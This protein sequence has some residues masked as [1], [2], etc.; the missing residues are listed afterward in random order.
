MVEEPGEHA[1]GVE[2]VEARCGSAA[3][4]RRR[5]RSARRGASRC[6]VSAAMYSCVP[7]SDPPCCGRTSWR[8][9]ARPARR[10]RRS[11][12]PRRRT[13]RRC[14]ASSPTA[15]RPTRR[16]RRDSTR[17]GSG[18]R[19][20]TAE[21]VGEPPGR[22]DRH[23]DDPPAAPCRFDAER[24]GHGR[25]ADAARSRSRRR[26]THRRRPLQRRRSCADWSST[27]PSSDAGAP[28][29]HVAGAA[30]PAWSIE[31]AG[32][33]GHVQLLQRQRRWPRWS[34]GSRCT[35][36]RSPRNSAADAATSAAVGR[37]RVRRS[38]RRADRRRSSSVSVRVD[39]D[40]V[41]DH[42]APA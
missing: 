4:R 8:R 20:S 1:G 10:R 28:P 29:R 14:R 35:R 39:V 13:P 7:L 36:R 22:V 42:R 16:S 18:P 27:R 17:L 9:C 6:S 40:A 41:D 37:R 24:R 2:E 31:P 23:D 3:C 38:P 30:A 25:L 21:G 26:R 5:G 32:D 19:P 11:G 12:E 15:R 34:I 33:E